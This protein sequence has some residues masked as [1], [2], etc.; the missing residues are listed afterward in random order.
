MNGYFGVLL[1]WIL[2]S[3]VCEGLVIGV[4]PLRDM[5]SS[6]GLV[7]LRNQRPHPVSS[8]IMLITR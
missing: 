4:L 8:Q 5:H 3:R 2:F 7:T 1:C 6:V